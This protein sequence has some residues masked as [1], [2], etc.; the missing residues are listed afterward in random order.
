MLYLFFISSSLAS[1]EAITVGPPAASVASAAASL[2][3]SWRRADP[4][5][6]AGAEGLRGVPLS[7]GRTGVAAREDVRRLGGG[8][9]APAASGLARERGV[10]LRAVTGSGNMGRVLADDVLA[11]ATPAATPAAA[12]AAPAVGAPASATRAP[13]VYRPPARQMEDMDVAVT[14]N[15]GKGMIKS[16]NEALKMPYMALGEE[17]D[18]TDLIALQ[19]SLKPIAEKQ[20]GYKI[21]LTAFFIKAISLALHEHPKAN[22]KFAATEPPSY[23]VF[24]SRNVPIVIDSK[25]G[26]MVP[27]VKDVSNLSVLG[28]Q[29]DVLRLAGAAQNNKFS[30]SDIKG[31]TITFSNIGMIGTEDPRP[32]PFDGQACIGALGRLVVVTAELGDACMKKHETTSCTSTCEAHEIHALLSVPGAAT[33]FASQSDAEE[34]CWM[35]HR[36]C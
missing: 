3:R 24:G 34:E 2:L 9:A 10:D 11:A 23:T 33:L 32:I 16:M 17:L 6:V 26:R 30:L 14:D 25:Y 31:G 12:V 29:Q 13:L 18:V 1:A 36:F 7:D 19:K 35:S 20:Y 21:S 15:V 8:E 4:P 22:S 27:N 5:G 28:M